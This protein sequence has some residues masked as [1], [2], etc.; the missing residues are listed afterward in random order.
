MI[1]T[2]T[3]QA[4]IIASDRKPV[5]SWLFTCAGSHWSTKSYSYG[6]QS[7]TFKVN[8]KSFDGIQ[9]SG[10]KS[11]LNIICPSGGSFEVFNDDDALSG[12]TFE[13]E[14][15]TIELVIKA[16]VSGSPV[17]DSIGTWSMRVVTC[18][19]FGKNLKFE[20]EDV[21][22]Q[23]L[24]GSWPSKT[25]VSTLAPNTSDIQDD[26]CVPVPFGTVYHSIRS[27]YI[28]GSR[29]YLLGESSGTYSIV[30]VRSPI[31]WP[32]KSTWLES[33]YTMTPDTGTLTG[34]TIFQ[35]IIAPG[36]ISQPTVI[37]ACGLFP[38][39]GGTWYDMPC[40]YSRS[41][42]ASLTDFEDVIEYIL[43][44]MG[45]P[46]ALLDTGVG[47]S[48]ETAGTS[49]S[50]WGLSFNY[51]FNHPEDKR[52]ILSNI[53]NACHAYFVVTDKVELHIK[54]K[55]SRKTITKDHIYSS[56][57]DGIGLGEFDFQ[58]IRKETAD[59]GHV[60]FAQAD[61]PQEEL[62]SPARIAANGGTTYNEFSSN[63]LVIPYYSNSQRA[64]RAGQ[65]RLQ[66]LLWRAGEASFTALGYLLHLRPGDMITI[67]E[68]DY[69]G[70]YKVRIED[71]YIQFNLL[72]K[73]QCAYYSSDLEDWGDV[74]P[75]AVSIETD[76]VVSPWSPALPNGGYSDGAVP[77]DPQNLSSMPWIKGARFTWTGN[78]ALDFD[79]FEYRIRV[80]NNAQDDYSAWSAWVETENGV[81]DYFLTEL[82]LTDY[83]DDAIVHIE[84]K[85]VNDSSVES[86][87]TVSASQEIQSLGI[88]PVEI[89]DFSLGASKWNTKIPVIE[90]DSWTDD[91][92]SGAPAGYIGWN[93]HY[94]YYNGVK[95]TI[96]AGNTAYKYIYWENL[97]SSYSASDTHPVLS[98]GEF[99][100]A[101][102]VDGAHDLAWNAI[103]NQVIGAAFI[104]DAS[105]GSAKISEIK[106]S[107][108]TTEYLAAARIEAGS[109]TLAK[110]SGASGTLQI[111]AGGK[112]EINASEALEI[113]GSG[114]IKILNNGNVRIYD[115]T[116]DEILRIG[117]DDGD[118]GLFLYDSSLNRL[119]A[120]YDTGL[121]LYGG[122]DIQLEGAVSNPASIKFYDDDANLLSS[123]YS[124]SS[125]VYTWW[126]GE[127]G[128]TLRFFGFDTVRLEGTDDVQ[129][130]TSYDADNWASVRSRASATD[131]KAYL[132][133]EVGGDVSRILLGESGYGGY[134]RVQ[135][136]LKYYVSG[137]SI[138]MGSGTLV[139]GGHARIGDSSDAVSADHALLIYGP[140]TG[141]TTDYILMCRDSG[142]NTAFHVRSDKFAKV[143]DDFNAVGHA[144]IGENTAPLSTSAL[145]L[146]G[147]GTTSSSYSLIC[148]D[149]AGT[150]Q[151]WV[152]DDGQGYLE[153]NDWTGSDNQFKSDIAKINIDEQ[154]VN[155]FMQLAPSSYIRK[156]SGILEKGL[157]AQDVL[158]VY[159]ESV[160]DVSTEDQRAGLNMNNRLA[161]LGL[162][163]KDIYVEHMCVTQYLVN[164]HN[165][166]KSD[167][168]FLRAAVSN[169]QAEVES[170]KAV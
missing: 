13:G 56:D 15:L 158:K 167:I 43:E 112:V 1:S 21:L 80:S 68:T 121:T 79:H 10:P 29:Y 35:P 54:R 147:P 82:E 14:T 106:A 148:K 150:N 152:R 162:S 118:L 90:S 142:G 170:L 71:M 94:L 123:I 57:P 89:D 37:N 20:Y 40:K 97:N 133:A 49:F 62:T 141:G 64:Q 156:K 60:I 25:K 103:A 126:E 136:T 12:S 8:P 18:K 122:G 31:E 124:D 48:F 17:E 30:K 46:S 55:I 42:T 149:S 33:G 163:Y 100:I 2:T 140:S 66:E 19:E 77:A 7:Y 155:R 104:Q 128:T 11:D 52:T 58:P 6:G 164:Q 143:Y 117:T 115:G 102:N 76:D 130:L 93:E 75:G 63:D 111:S 132:Y 108:I 78:F 129:L 85:S 28:S 88:D 98:D 38:S 99:I 161:V 168:N 138:D 135:G 127:S 36:D 151:M 157:I 84:V 45:V 166:F 73:F 116:P 41:D 139:C 22:S 34:Y 109:M 26:M 153:S 105:I 16:Y 27:L 113:G 72:T 74:T 91:Y 119:A 107:L 120:Y 146:Y 83:G 125:A 92:H 67:N 47:S 110:L 137:F 53:L 9:I 51:A 39:G 160:H 81:A 101:T 59:S 165:D 144:M 169:L 44:D 65:L 96:A 159:P 145:T 4:N 23:Y 50:A 114:S 87:N 3:Q 131:S 61:A 95:Y 154:V 32:G 86:T 70:N 134:I 69:G 5:V 24:E